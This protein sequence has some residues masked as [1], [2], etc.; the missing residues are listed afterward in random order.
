MKNFMNLNVGFLVVHN[1][2]GDAI[3][4]ENNST[5]I[6]Y[7]NSS[8]AHLKLSADAT[9]GHG[10]LVKSATT[11]KFINIC[12]FKYFEVAQGLY[13]LRTQRSS[14][15]TFDFVD[16]EN[17]THPISLG[18]QGTTTNNN[19]YGYTFTGGYILPN[20]ECT[21]IHCSLYAHGNK[22]V[23][24]WIDGDFD[25]IPILDEQ[26]YRNPNSYEVNLG[27]DIDP[28]KISI[29]TTTE[30]I[31][32]YRSNSE[33]QTK[34]Q[35]PNR[36]KGYTQAL[37]DSTTLLATTAFTMTNGKNYMARV[38][39]A[40]GSPLK[41]WTV[42]GDITDATITMVINDSEILYLAVWLD[43]AVE[44]TGVTFFQRTQGVYTADNNN[45]VGLYSYSGGTLTKVAESANNGNLFKGTADTFVQQAF[46][47]P[48]TPTVAGLYYVAFIYNQSAQST[49]PAIAAYYT[50]TA[51]NQAAP[52]TS[53]SA[54]LYGSS[55][56][57]DLP[58]SIAMSSIDGSIFPFWLGVY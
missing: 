41:G 35:F 19:S 54:K 29:L 17:V 8:F 26:E 45:K 56:S 52:L 6:L 46:S 28:T 40:L 47:T 51:S 34:I 30:T 18:T 11:T 10:L 24:V 36:T 5:T 4:M 43:S 37:G 57:T 13:G 53:N 42:G 32:I 44:L 21:S 31:L 25:S 3:I 50:Q 12:A 49:Q 1:I 55:Y 7:G 14:N 58:S 48:Y 22:F 16:I 20:P 39:S 15:F 23:N 33:Y 38:L 27:Y 2:A 9:V